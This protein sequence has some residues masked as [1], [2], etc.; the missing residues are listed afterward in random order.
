MS[1]QRRNSVP[2]R[3]W[4]RACTSC[5]RERRMVAG[6]AC[7][8]HSTRTFSPGLTAGPSFARTPGTGKVRAPPS[9]A[10]STFPWNVGAE[11]WA[12]ESTRL[13]TP[14]RARLRDATT[15]I[16]NR[17][18]INVASTALLLTVRQIR[19]GQFG[20]FSSRG[21]SSS[22][23]ANAGVAASRA[24]TRASRR[25][26]ALSASRAT[27]TSAFGLRVQYSP[28]PPV[29]ESNI[30]PSRSSTRP[31]RRARFSSPSRRSTISWLIS[32]EPGSAHQ[33][34]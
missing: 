14:E 7:T 26:R 19:A 6:G 13:L 24:V 22:V 21:G 29:P 31:T 3:G 17:L 4:R 23:S 10:R 16:T 25:S 18:P 5:R 20:A 12:M 34:S 2:P 15:A 11:S 8:R 33:Q 1:S 32:S 9:P 27:L 28:A 30:H